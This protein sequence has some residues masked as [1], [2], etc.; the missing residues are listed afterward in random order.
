MV[1]I[2]TSNIKQAL[3]TKYNLGVC[4]LLEALACM[5]IG[6]I[7]VVATVDGNLAVNI[8]GTIGYKVTVGDGEV[9]THLHGA[10][11]MDVALEV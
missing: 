11:H 9:A 1:I 8:K 2:G 7:K 10:T 5:Q 4:H 6:S 3:V